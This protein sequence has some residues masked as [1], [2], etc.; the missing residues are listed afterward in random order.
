[1]SERVE[2]KILSLLKT[3]DVSPYGNPI[4]GLAELGA[5]ENSSFGEGVVSVSSLVG[6]SD[7]KTYELARIGEPLQVFP[8]LLQDMK[9]AGVIPGAKVTL[10]FEPTMVKIVSAHGD[11]ELRRDFAAHLFLRS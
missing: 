7:G 5:T 10:E 2:R 11:L 1:M 6:E 3:V 9:A 4:P 8:E